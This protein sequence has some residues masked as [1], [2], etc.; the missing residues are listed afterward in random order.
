MKKLSLDDFRKLR[1]LVYRGANPA[2]FADW[3][4]TFENG[5]PG[6]VL[7]VMACYQNDDGGFGYYAGDNWNP[8][9]SPDA[10]NG[11]VFQINRINRFYPNA[12]DKN[13]PIY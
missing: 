12:T 3:R 13:N 9:S 7:S 1:R 6:D 10:T 5:N 8:N 2:I 11:A 4:F